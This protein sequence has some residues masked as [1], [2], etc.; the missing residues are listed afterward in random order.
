MSDRTG[1]TIL[2]SV[3]RVIKTYMTLTDG[4]VWLRGE[5]EFKPNNASFAVVVGFSQGPKSFCVKASETTIAGSYFEVI[6]QNNAAQISIDIE[7][8]DFNV[9]ERKEEIVSAMSSGLCKEAQI[10]D[11]FSIGRDPTTANDLS[12]IDGMAIPYR[13]RFT[14]TVQFLTTKTK[15]I[16]YYDNFDEEDLHVST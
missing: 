2:K 8:R 14:F 16:E 11:G 13:F 15:T 12:G 10:V 9:L 4:Q 6:E 3:A 7:G 5:K 1:A